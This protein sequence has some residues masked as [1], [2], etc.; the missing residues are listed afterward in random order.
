[1]RAVRGSRVA[2]PAGIRP[3]AIHISGGTITRVAP[4]D[5]VPRGV[6]PIDAGDA[7][8]FPGL[9]DTHV[10]VNEP[11]RTD[12]EGFAT[13]TRAAAAGG[14]TTLLDMPLN[15]IPPTTSVPA[16][17]AKRAAARGK[18]AVDVGFLGGL[19]PGGAGEIPGLHQAGVFGLKC[20][21]CPSGVDEFPP[22]SVAD[23]TAS[24]PAL[25]EA[26]VLLMV[27]AE[28]PAALQPGAAASRDPRSHATWLATRPAAAETEA[29]RF[30]IELAR[31]SG[32]RVHVVHVSSAA[33]LELIAPAR[34]A[35]VRITS[36]TCPHYL[37]F[38]AEEIPDG[39]TEYKCAPPVRGTAE[40]EAL[41]TA[42]EQGRLDAVVSDH[43][44]APPE[45]KRRAEGD[46][47]RAWGGI[48]SLQLRLPAVWTGARARGHAPGRVVEWLCSGPAR[49]AGLEGRKG[50][51]APG[52]DADLVLWRPE[53]EFVVEESHLRHRHTLTPWLGRRLAGV[54]EATY[55]RGEPVYARGAPDG[56]PR[57]R[58]LVRPNS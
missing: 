16:L 6:D 8:V 1:M 4:F 25:A 24:T 17:E 22:V 14:V 49:L 29:V 12:W 56:P 55:L 53:A 11:G 23:L 42:L 45:S 9:V 33:T 43:S 18:C 35:G 26:N 5:D 13:A 57:G 3:A 31:S 58:L 51:I 41:W 7:L 19:V 37:G 47:L 52:A 40:R 28:S 30:L 34:A 36:E 38:A 2:T 21:L 32:I 44:P 39:A 20:F 54:V 10:H 48:A 15:S 50:V 46:F 27:H